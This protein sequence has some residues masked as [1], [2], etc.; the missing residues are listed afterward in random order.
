MFGFFNYPGNKNCAWGIEDLPKHGN[1]KVEHVCREEWKYSSG[2]FVSDIV[3]VRKST[4]NAASCSVSL[5]GEY[6][7]KT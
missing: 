2:H 7:T 6:F 4:F 3:V 5:A 1:L